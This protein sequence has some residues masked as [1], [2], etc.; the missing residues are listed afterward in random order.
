MGS[1][2]GARGPPPRPQVGREGAR[3]GGGSL[4]GDLPEARGAGSLPLL[5][6]AD[7][8]RSQGHRGQAP[9]QLSRNLNPHLTS[10]LGHREERHPQ[11]PQEDRCIAVPFFSASKSP[12]CHFSTSYHP[13]LREDGEVCLCDK[14]W[15]S[16]RSSPV[17]S[18]SS[19]GGPQGT[20]LSTSKRWN[21]TCAGL[22]PGL[23]ATSLSVHAALCLM[24]I[25]AARGP[26]TLERKNSP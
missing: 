12:T 18:P 11:T 14:Q 4:D 20:A 16:Q 7:A 25:L 2:K 5:L 1:L 8:E 23:L 17:P 21:P 10:P 3:S 15:R 26:G 22:T 6:T 24:C 19:A 9:R 13:Q